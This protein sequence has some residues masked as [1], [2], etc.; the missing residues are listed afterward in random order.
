MN[1]YTPPAASPPYA[2]GGYG[3]VAPYREPVPNAPTD[4]A[5]EYL[6]QTRPWVMLMAVLCFLGAGLMCMAGVGMTAMGLISSS[7]SSSSPLP[8]WIIG[9]VYVPLGGMYVY[10][11]IK[12]WAYSTSIGRVVA[13]RSI[14][15]LE[16]ALMHQKSFWKFCGIAVIVMFVLYIFMFIG[17]MVFGFASAV[18]KHH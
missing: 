11:G 12:L 3:A 2:P 16:Q 1:L 14:D 15:D 6:K 8:M 10:P 18:G 4:L 5:V 7:M 17:M 9:L 13:N